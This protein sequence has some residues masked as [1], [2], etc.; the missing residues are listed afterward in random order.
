MKF[1]K[2]AKWTLGGVAVLATFLVVALLYAH[3]VS[4][5]VTDEDRSSVREYLTDVE[6]PQPGISF[7]SDV[8]FIRMVQDSVLT[9]APENK[10]IPFGQPRE[11]KDLLEAKK[12]LCFDRSRVIEKILRIYG[13][14]TRHIFIYTTK[15]TGSSLRSFIT[16][17]VGSHAVSEVRT[18]KGW[19]VVDSNDRWISLDS[20]GDPRGME[21]L[22]DS[23]FKGR[24]VSW[25]EEPPEIY[26]KLH[27]YTFVYGLY[28]RHGEFYP[29]YN[30][31][32]DVNYGELLYNIY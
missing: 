7:E 13:F 10:G 24:E 4:N 21:D 2:A 22:A 32:P 8:E 1:G 26:T 27:P 28:S 30:A 19:L 9:V 16:P 20:N 29:P 18:A 5:E 31:I 11:P 15:A 23:L 17:G 14:E 25:K 3:S 12:G 6:P